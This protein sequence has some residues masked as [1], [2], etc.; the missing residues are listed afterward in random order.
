MIEL[1]IILKDLV[2][3]DSSNPPGN[4]IHIAD[5]ITTFFR[6]HS[7][8]QIEFQELPNGNKNVIA[9]FGKPNIVI[10]AHLDTVPLSSKHQGNTLQFHENENNYCGR[11]T[12]DVKGA[13]AAMLHALQYEQP[14]NALF[15][16]NP[17]E[18]YGGNTGIQK[19]LSSPYSKEIQRCISTEPTA[20]QI[21]MFH[22]G[23]CT[24]QIDFEGKSAHAC[25]PDNG[26]NAIELASDFIQK[27]RKFK[28]TLS[29]QI[30]LGLKPTLNIAVIQGGIKP[31]MIPD[32]CSL[33][34]SYRY[35]PDDT[36]E[37]ATRRIQQ[38][39]NGHPASTKVLYTAPPLNYGIKDTLLLEMLRDCGVENNIKTANFWSEAAL[40]AKAGISSV[41]FG[42]G[43]IQQAHTDEE[44]IAKSELI[45]S[46]EIYKNL[47]ARC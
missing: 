11:G 38:I 28:E 39:A 10:N 8:A 23:I 5:Y 47:F 35:L 22:N 12:V 46:T 42:P 44:Y 7:N 3:I 32:R 29:Q 33:T 30:F 2:S 37:Q 6:N 36:A 41:V 18:E 13:I 17:D 15:L 40:L 9:I 25:L 45:K 20:C 27:I 14:K 24:M 1:A 43:D 31:N 21:V 16:F 19:F 4:C 34:L 26:I